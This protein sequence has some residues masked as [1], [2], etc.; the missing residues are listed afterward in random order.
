MVVAQRKYICSFCAK[1]FSRSEHRIRHERS[2]T[3][4]KPFQCILCQHSFVRRDLVQRHIKTVHKYVL[5]NNK[6]ILLEI[7]DSLN[8]LTDSKNKNNNNDG[9]IKNKTTIP[10]NFNI[11]KIL[12]DL[13]V[14]LERHSNS[15]SNFDHF[16]V[17]NNINTDGNS[18]I[19]AVTEDELS[20]LDK[21]VKFFVNYKDSIN[22][23]KLDMKKYSKLYHKDKTSS[24]VGNESENKQNDTE[25][26]KKPFLNSLSNGMVIFQSIS[27]SVNEVENVSNDNK[28][29]LDTSLFITQICSDD[30]NWINYINNEIFINLR[31]ELPSLSNFNVSDFIK[32]FNNGFKF[33]LVH[34]NFDDD[35]SISIS[36]VS[37]SPSISTSS[38]TSNTDNLLFIHYL[39]HSYKTL[40]SLWGVNKLYKA[41]D[42]SDNCNNSRNNIPTKSYKNFKKNIPILPLTIVYL[43]YM[44]NNTVNYQLWNDLW[45]L[46][47]NESFYNNQTERVVTISLLVFEFIQQHI[48]LAQDTEK[49]VDIYSASSPILNRLFDNYQ[50]VLLTFIQSNIDY[51]SM[52][53]NQWDF[54]SLI[55]IWTSFLQF[56]D[57]LLFNKISS[58]IYFKIISIHS[59]WNQFNQNTLKNLIQ[60]GIDHLINEYIP[61]DLLVCLPSILYLEA[62]NNRFLNK[63][64]MLTLGNFKSMEDLHNLI[65]KINQCYIQNNN[66]R[67]KTNNTNISRVNTNQY[68]DTLT[69]VKISPILVNNHFSTKTTKYINETVPKSEEYISNDINIWKKNLMVSIAPQRFKPII[70]NYAIIPTTLSHWL[71][72]ETTWF[73]FIKNLSNAEYIFKKNCFLDNVLN[74]SIVFN[75]ES[76]NNNL[77]ICSLPVILLVITPTTNYLNVLSP[78]FKRFLPLIIDVLLIQLKLICSE[79]NLSSN[80]DKTKIGGFLLNPLIQ[81][82]LYVWYIIIYKMDGTIAPVYSQLEVDSVNTFMSKYIMNLEKHIDT[83][84]LLEQ[85]LDKI[86]FDKEAPEHMGFDFFLNRV[87]SFIKNELLLNKVLSSPYLSNNI[88]FKLIE[89]VKIFNTDDSYIV[90]DQSNI[91]N[92]ANEHGTGTITSITT[93]NNNNSLNFVSIDEDLNSMA[94]LKQNEPLTLEA[95][96]INFN[97]LS[98]SLY[99]LGSQNLTSPFRKRNSTSS[100]SNSVSKPTSSGRLSL[101]LGASP[102][103]LSPYLTRRRSSVMSVTDDGK[104]YLLPPLNF[105]PIQMDTP[106]LSSIHTSLSNEAIASMI[107]NP[108]TNSKSTNNKGGFYLN[109]SLNG[110][111]NN[112]NTFNS[113]CNYNLKDAIG[114]SPLNKKRRASVPII[115][116]KS[117][118]LIGSNSSNSI[119][120]SV[121]HAKNSIFFNSGLHSRT[122]S[123]KNSVFRHPVVHSYVNTNI[124]SSSTLVS[125]S[126]LLSNNHVLAKSASGRNNGTTH[127]ANLVNNSIDMS[128][129]DNNSSTIVNN[130][131]PREDLPEPNI[132]LPSPSQL[133]GI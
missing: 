19:L 61:D 56:F 47:L 80:N 82:L 79:L 28:N 65:I 93:A 99:T 125:G 91:N 95:K 59:I 5:L 132:Q 70:K 75:S 118:F 34:G 105:D 123:S 57:G 120:T 7:I 31:N 81:L 77:S 17:K 84:K 48:L 97:S 27:N 109:E 121:N 87:T 29:A 53:F 49:Y 110:I 30:I 54:N 68:N 92:I 106:L 58:K 24:I 76:I 60:L 116:T 111:N 52:H 11:L 112:N 96:P 104:N 62:N 122:P 46:S 72:I 43:G 42:N 55:L 133:F 71:L 103:S 9:H 66:Y 130:L 20:I 67:S 63:E 108:I 89:A 117:I 50:L 94:S 2:H 51:S 3:G 6:N 113:L 10:S 25:A 69:I 131:A 119:N 4:Y 78:R 100:S 114:K 107:T 74:E 35:E 8:E 13:N 45:L 37:S 127:P 23:P 36:S 126:T 38:F 1:A 115:P 14:N 39:T 85:D 129:N 16:H 73:E 128:I 124:P 40:E 64:K 88:K 98:T 22:D 18:H 33:I 102:I 86:L 15:N 41:N 101:A 21:I 44:L 83:D 26:C 90:T 32:Y 12:K